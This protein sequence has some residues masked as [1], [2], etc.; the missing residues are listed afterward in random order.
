MAIVSL[1]PLPLLFL[2][3]EFSKMKTPSWFY[4]KGRG[5]GGR[6]REDGGGGRWEVGGGR[7]VG[8]ER[9]RRR[10]EGGGRWREVGGEEWER[11]ET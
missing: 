7:W 8:G 1:S 3:P 6:R 4:P 5:K 10:E 9:V 11:W 2:C